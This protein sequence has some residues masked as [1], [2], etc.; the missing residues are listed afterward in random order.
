MV[1]N[2]IADLAG[3]F[4]QRTAKKPPRPENCEVTTVKPCEKAC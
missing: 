2:T 4:S 3:I 1:S